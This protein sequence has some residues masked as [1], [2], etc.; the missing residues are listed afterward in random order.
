M[1]KSLGSST[2]WLVQGVEPYAGAFRDNVREFLSAHGTPGPAVDQPHVSC[3][4]VDLRGSQNSVKLHVYEEA[5]DE[6]CPAFCDPCRIVGA[7][8]RPAEKSRSYMANGSCRLAHCMHSCP[9]VRR[10]RHVMTWSGMRRPAGWQH[11]AVCKRRYHFIIPAQMPPQAAAE[12][13]NLPAL[14]ACRAA[15][16]A[17]TQQST[18]PRPPQ[19]AHDAASPY[20]APA[21]V[22]DAHSHLLHG[23]LHANGFGHLLRINGLEGGSAV[24]TGPHGACMRH[25]IHCHSAVKA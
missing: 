20:T 23:V 1:Q 12:A 22:F 14:V 9:Y 10:S 16:P 19:Q 7:P 6:Q 25:H 24:L 21:S 17:M 4:L 15:D 2:P 11:H 5:L 13:G 3:W 8:P 18:Q